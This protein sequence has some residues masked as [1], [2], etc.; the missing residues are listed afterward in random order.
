MNKIV[1]AVVGLLAMAGH[2]CAGSISR[3]YDFDEL[4]GDLPGKF[5]YA[6]V[7]DGSDIY[8]HFYGYLNSKPE[9]SMSGITRMDGNGQSHTLVSGFDW[10]DYTGSEKFSALYNFS[11]SGNSLY[12]ADLLS[13][14]VYS[15]DKNTGAIST[16]ATS[17]AIRAVIGVEDLSFLGAGDLY[18]DKMYF[19][20]RNS[21]NILRA[22]LNGVE[23]VM[24]EQALISLMGNSSINGS[25]TVTDDNH[26]YW[27]GGESPSLY[28]LDMNSGAASVLLT[29]SEIRAAGPIEG[30]DNDV[31][32]QDIYQAP[33]GYLYF[34]D[35]NRGIMSYSADSDTLAMVVSVQELVDSEV[36]MLS[37]VYNFTWYDDSLAFCHKDT[38]FYVVTP[39]PLAISFLISG[40]CLALRRRNRRV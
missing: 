9:L 35:R 33:D 12:F 4:R 40:G 37:A 17:E 23:V 18:Q 31:I 28:T 1:V 15:V 29:N 25:M 16:I 3:V 22:G 10:F 32:M 13:K 5:L 2:A 7:A 6:A 19:F 27:C 39:E 11:L 34:F 26:L 8:C 30:I 38:G 24:Q 21:R 36:G 14:Q 20:E